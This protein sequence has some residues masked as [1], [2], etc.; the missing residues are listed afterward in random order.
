MSHYRL[1]GWTAS[2]SSMQ[3]KRIL[4]IRYARSVPRG[5]SREIL[6]DQFYPVCSPKLLAKGPTIRRPSDLGGYPLIHFD[7]F[8]NDPTAPNWQRWF[9]MASVSDPRAGNTC[10]ELH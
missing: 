2:S 8:A 3:T 4:Q 10:Q 6:R 5:A 9:E 7:W 1:L